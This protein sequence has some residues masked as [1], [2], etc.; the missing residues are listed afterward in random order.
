MPSAAG[1]GADISA[2]LLTN[3]LLQ[4]LK[5][6]FVIDNRPSSGGLIGRFTSL[7]LAPERIEQ[8]QSREAVEV[9]VCGD[10]Q[11]AMLDR[12]RSQRSV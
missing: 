10:Q 1:N 5:Q 4:Q 8:L 7:L 3:E 6:Q 12:K 9:A 2:R 11:S